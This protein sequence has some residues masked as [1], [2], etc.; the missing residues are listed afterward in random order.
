MKKLL[1]ALITEVLA[2][3]LFLEKARSL[4]DIKHIP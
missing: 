1:T 2:L 4:A 3:P